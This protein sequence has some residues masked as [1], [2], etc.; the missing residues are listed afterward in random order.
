LAPGLLAAIMVHSPI[1]EM[2]SLP[3]PLGIISFDER[4]VQRA[5]DKLQGCLPQ[6]LDVCGKL[7]ATDPRAF[8]EETLLLTPQ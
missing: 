6:Y 2:H 8:V 4:V 3:I 1:G 7:P 5:Q